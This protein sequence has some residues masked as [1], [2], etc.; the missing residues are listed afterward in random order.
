MKSWHRFIVLPAAMLALGGCAARTPK[1]APAS[2]P[3][4][5]SGVTAPGIPTNAVAPHVMLDPKALEWRPF[6]AGG[7]GTMI[8]VLAGDPAK[9]GPFVVRLKQ[10]RGAKIPPHWHPTDEHVTV[11]EGTLALG[12]GETYDVKGLRAMPAGSYATLPRE[13]RHFGRSLTKTVVQI[14]GMGPFQVIFVNPAD[15]PRNAPGKQ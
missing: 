5:A 7:P 2:E 15:D 4:K 12:M 14:H 6:P 8:A 10:P 1:A 13:M 3:V 11:I 9:P